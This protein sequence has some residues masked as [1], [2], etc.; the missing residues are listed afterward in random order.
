MDCVCF[1]R[2]GCFEILDGW[3]EV[4]HSDSEFDRCFSR[5][6]FDQRQ[7]GFRNCHGDIA[8]LGGIRTLGEL[9]KDGTKRVSV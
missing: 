5:T 4:G 2:V 6:V 8:T 1:R 7:C 3:K 9:S